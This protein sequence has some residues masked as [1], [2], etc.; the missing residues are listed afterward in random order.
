[1]STLSQEEISLET[2]LENERYK[3]AVRLS[4]MLASVFP[5]LHLLFQICYRYENFN[6]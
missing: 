5:H 2:H 6:T 1:M 3:L 4:L